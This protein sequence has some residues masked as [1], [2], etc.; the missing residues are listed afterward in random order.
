MHLLQ[1]IGDFHQLLI[2]VLEQVLQLRLRVEDLHVECVRV[3]TDAERARDRLGVS[4]VTNRI[5]NIHH[6]YHHRHDV[7]ARHIIK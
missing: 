3:V 6:H 2:D 1:G 4:S 7:T 5:N